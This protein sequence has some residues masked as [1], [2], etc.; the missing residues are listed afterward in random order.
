MLISALRSLILINILIFILPVFLGE[1]GIWLT[2][3]LTE[4]IT[5]IVSYAFIRKSRARLFIA[6]NYGPNTTEA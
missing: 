2:T 4:A 5:F 3:P 6:D 1:T